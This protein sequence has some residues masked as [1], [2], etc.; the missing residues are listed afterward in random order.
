MLVEPDDR[1]PSFPPQRRHMLC[2]VDSQPGSSSAYRRKSYPPD[3]ICVFQRIARKGLA[4]NNQFASQLPQDRMHIASHSLRKII[5]KI[6]ESRLILNVILYSQLECF[7]I[8]SGNAVPSE[9]S[10]SAADESKDLRFGTSIHASRFENTG[11]AVQ[12]ERL[13]AMEPTGV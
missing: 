10:S 1:Q 5:K 7:E 11:R 4:G 3:G 6:D 13:P 2:A 8:C 9:R 12:M